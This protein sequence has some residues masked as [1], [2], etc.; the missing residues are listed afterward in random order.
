MTLAETNTTRASFDLPDL[1]M[2]EAAAKSSVAATS[3]GV[4]ARLRLARALTNSEPARAIVIATEAAGAAQALGL[5]SEA[6]RCRSTIGF[7]HLA[8]SAID[9]A[10]EIAET[11]CAE[12][13]TPL[14]RICVTLLR[15]VIK[16]REGDLAASTDLALEALR[17]PN[18]EVHEYTPERA[19]LHN[20]LGNLSAQFGDSGASVDHYQSALQVLLAVG[21]R[22][23]IALVTNNI[24]M[25]L[26]ESQQFDDALRFFDDALVSMAGLPEGLLHATIVGNAGL[27]LL[28]AGRPDQAHDPL[29]DVLKRMEALGVP[30]GIGSSNHNLGRL[31]LLRGELVRA[32]AY[33]QQARIHREALGEK[34]DLSDTK[35][36]LVNLYRAMGDDKQAAALLVELLDGPDACQVLRVRAAALEARYLLLRAAGRFEEALD[37]HVAFHE[38]SRAYVDDRANARQQVILARFRHAELDHERLRERER[39]AAFERLSLTDSLTGL[40]NRRFVETRLAGEVRRFGLR[41]ESLCVAVLDVDHFKSINDRFSHGVGDKTLQTIA[42]LLRDDIRPFDMAAR[43]GGEEFLL[44]F[45]G[46][47]LEQGVAA[48]ERLRLRLAAHD[49]SGCHADLRVTASFGVVEATGGATIEQL[50]QLAD[51]ALYRAKHNGR[52]RVESATR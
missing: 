29:I 16:H 27:T 10:R 18:T 11:L 38:A 17:I 5:R 40:P 14:D 49:W 44:A 46:N 45:P 8:G 31:M 36:Q 30:R 32:E 25:A 23:A 7:A 13:E 6:F 50:I 41:G 9:T 34:L 39:S 2:L 52:N 12:V 37:A 15:G 35:L 43:L 33:L 1:A 42:S 20:L 4:A 21:H 28:E 51:A 26:R 24:G 47:Q 3:E 19:A 22:E 48:C